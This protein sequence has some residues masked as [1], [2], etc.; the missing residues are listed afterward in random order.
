MLPDARAGELIDRTEST[1][2]EERRVSEVLRDVR[3]ARG[4]EVLADLAAHT[5]L[6]P[7]IERAAQEAEEAR[8][9]DEHER[10]EAPRIAGGRETLRDRAR[11][12]DRLVLLGGLVRLERARAPIRMIQVL[13]VLE[14]AMKRA[15]PTNR[16]RCTLP[17]AVLGVLR[18]ALRTI[19]RNGQ[20]QNGARAHHALRDAPEEHVR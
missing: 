9:S 2:D 20:R 16:S 10:I 11:E 8:L 13:H 3:I 15:L 12:P 17:F 5:L 14:C 1:R 19:G 4:D 6:R 7:V 18:G